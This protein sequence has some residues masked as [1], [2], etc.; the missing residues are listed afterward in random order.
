MY[1][2]YL[3]IS[4]CLFFNGCQSFVTIPVTWILRESGWS[5]FSWLKLF[6]SEALP[7][8]FFILFFKSCVFGSRRQIVYFQHC[9][10]LKKNG[11]IPETKCICFIVCLLIFMLSRLFDS[12]C[13]SE[14][15]N[16]TGNQSQPRSSSSWRLH[17]VMKIQAKENAEFLWIDFGKWKKYAK[18]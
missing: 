10:I 7:K 9:F 13:H 14:K 2:L 17:C 11:W 8:F 3:P 18:F 6:L 16:V 1:G 4:I 12:T 5:I 15:K